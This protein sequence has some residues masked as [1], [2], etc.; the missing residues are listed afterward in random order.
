MGIIMAEIPESHRD[1]LKTN[2]ATL[3]TVGKSGFPQVSAIWFLY[4][5]DGLV[6]LS[7]NTARQKV[8]NLQANP[9]CT[10][11]IMDPASPQRTLEIRARAELT[12]DP[13]YEF[14]DHFG[15]KYGGAD[16]RT[17]DKPGEVRVKVTLHPTRVVA[18]DLTRR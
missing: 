11:F 10:L 7:L 9:Q 13:D 1:L 14:A 3:A 16:L 2:V 17:R 18:V 15:K 4:D 12:L 6:R 8:K 5:D